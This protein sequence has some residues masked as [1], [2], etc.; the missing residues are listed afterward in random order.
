MA[1]FP[2]S[3]SI[4]QTYTVGTITWEWNG[5]AWVV[6]TGGTI[7]LSLDDLTD[8]EINSPQQDEVLKYDG[9]IWNNDGSLD[10]GSF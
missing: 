3:P 8:V 9:T 1:G 4:G 10:G 6:K 5:V 2:N 7:N